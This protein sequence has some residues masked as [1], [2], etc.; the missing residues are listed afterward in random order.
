MVTLGILLACAMAFG[1][2]IVVQVQG[3]DAALE[4]LVDRF[5]LVP[6]ELVAAVQAGN[7]VAQP[8]LDLFTHMFLHGS[9]LHLFGNAL[10][11]WIFGP[12]VEDRLGRP[13]FLVFYLV[14]GIVAALGHVLVD[15]TSDLAMI[16]ASGAI[17]AVLG[18]YLVLYPRAR[19]QSLVF[20]VFYY[21]LVEVPA[22]AV[23]G[24]WFGLQLID[25]FASL[26]LTDEIGGGV[27]FWA[28]IAGFVAGMLMALP[29]RALRRDPA[30][31]PEGA[32]AGASPAP[33]A[34]TAGASPTPPAET[35][36][37]G[38]LGGTTPPLPPPPPPALPVRPPPPPGSFGP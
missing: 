35:P 13:L 18:G 7:L 27:A 28:H 2:E 33:S 31:R 30:A 25:G 1:V 26:G 15:P 14:G 29:L 21:D 37:P 23:L 12:R 34:R 9:W 8:T 16:G 11:L 19:V 5:G 24:F 4:A 38:P 32:P 17:A 20:P 36:A 3:G 10:F 6:A 22:V